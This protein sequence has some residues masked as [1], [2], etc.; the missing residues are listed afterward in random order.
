MAVCASAEDCFLL[1]VHLIVTVIASHSQAIA[2]QVGA[3]AGACTAG[4]AEC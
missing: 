1:P 4:A 3:C 2:E